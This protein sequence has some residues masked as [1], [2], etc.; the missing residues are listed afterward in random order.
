M[1]RFGRI[2]A[3]FAPRRQSTVRPFHYGTRDAQ[4]ASSPVVAPTEVDNDET[5]TTEA[6]PIEDEVEKHNSVEEKKAKPPTFKIEIPKVNI[7][8][9]IKTMQL[10]HTHGLTTEGV[11]LGSSPEP[12]KPSRS[13]ISVRQ[14]GALAARMKNAHAQARRGAG[15]KATL[16]RRQKLPLMAEDT[17]K[18]LLELVND[19]DVAIVLA[20]TGCGK[21]T[22]VPQILLDDMI[23]SSRG[24]CANIVCTQPRR[25]AATSIA[26]RVA[27][28]RHATIGG[29]VGY[30]IRNE[31]RL[32]VSSGSIT[33][34]TTGILLNR[35]ISDAERVLLEHS[36]II[37][38]EVHERDIQIDLVLSLLRNAVRASKAAGRP[39]PKVILMSATIDPSSFLAYFTRPSHDGTT[40]TADYVDVEGR[41]AHI[42]NHYLPEILLD[43]SQEG[44]LQEPMYQYIQGS[45]V[46][47]SRR[48]V[49]HEMQFAAKRAKLVSA[50]D[51]GGTRDSDEPPTSVGDDES[52]GPTGPLYVG[53][54]AS[55][56][57][58]IALTKPEGDILAFFPGA[59]DME[60]VELLLRSG[61]FVDTGLDVQDPKKIRLFKLHSLRRETNNHVFDPVPQGCRRIILATNIAETSI[62]LPEVV[63]VVDT[64][65]ER[66]S[67]FDP[68]TLAKSLPY[69]WISKTSSIQRRGRAGRV[70]SGHY[71]ALF[72][73]ERHDSFRPMNRPEIGESDLA[74][75]ALQFKAFSQHADVEDL[76]LDT[77]EPP[78]RPAVDNAIR[79]LQGLGALTGTGDITSLGRLLWQLGVHPALGKAILLGCLFGCLEPMLIIACH[80]AGSP[81]IS[82]LELSMERV[83]EVRKRYLPEYETDFAWIIEAFREYHAA[84]IAGDGNLMLELQ[85]TKH[86]RHRAYLDMMITCE[87]LHHVLARKGFVPAPQ[88]GKT[89]F[90]MLPAA[91]NAHRND[92]VLVKALLINTVSAELAAWSD[93]QPSGWTVD[94]P[95]LRGLTSKFGVNEAKTNS[96]RRRK[97]KYRTHGRL[98]AYTYKRE[99][100][101]GPDDVVFLEQASMVTPLM[102]LLFCQSLALQSEHTL[103]LNRWLLLQ[104]KATADVPPAVATKVATILL[105]LRKTIDRLVS[106][107]WL[108][109]EGLDQTANGSDFWGDSPQRQDQK[110]QLRLSPTLRKVMVDAVVERLVQAAPEEDFSDDSPQGQDQKYQLRLSPVLRKVMV[111]AVVEMLH[112]DAAYWSDFKSRRRKWIDREV[113]RLASEK[114][115]AAALL[116]DV[117]ADID[118]IDEDDDGP[119]A[120]GESDD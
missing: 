110:H 78:S 96:E 104:L 56:I 53:L 114:M 76:L 81:L 11:I 111:D 42:E 97:R 5:N 58:H 91:L 29:T 35:L 67:L 65:K 103:Q 73:K 30:H 43:M 41:H 21:T 113:E 72:T 66:N 79:Q 14:D 10:A 49:E 70:R 62:T 38:D 109:L 60:N 3:A 36:H 31:D 116:E 75:V 44:A 4:G 57:A 87:G 25:L 108:D 92:M 33:Y 120:E 99:A 34:C 80:D 82:N 74:E 18:A 15:M 106:L 71:Y 6:V 1:P 88:P 40:L 90:E 77:L 8:S 61:R 102:A 69:A 68:S 9:A 100:S 95:E 39:H 52:A 101:D 20:K 119:E 19:N 98:M 89:L 28:E 47:S 54:A 7:Q 24:P 51:G 105:E 85:E 86:I 84:K 64:G 59:T 23:I 26:Q 22:Q 32:P 48:F 37:I 93:A 55:V 50:L 117:K 63:Y 107:A 46:M 27:Q 17:L 16:S 118:Q 83:R 13:P 12:A 112:A 45:H 115:Q 2:C 94:S